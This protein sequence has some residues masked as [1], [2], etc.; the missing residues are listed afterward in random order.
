MKGNLKVLFCCKK[1]EKTREGDL[2]FFAVRVF[3]ANQN[4][5]CDNLISDRNSQEKETVCNIRSKKGFL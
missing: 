1:P 5:P 2:V 4:I 3:V